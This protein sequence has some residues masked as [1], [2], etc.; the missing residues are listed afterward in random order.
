M[1]PDFLFE[2]SWEVCNKVGGIHTVIST[3]AK[4]LVNK[5]QDNYI[6]IGPDISKGTN[7][8]YEFIEDTHLYKAWKIYAKSKG[9][10]IRIGRWN[11]VGNPI[12]ILIDFSPFFN[13]KDAVLYELWDSFKVNSESGGWDYIEPLLF[14]Y[15]AGKVIENYYE[16]YHSAN[17][18][19]VAHFHEW[20]TGSG[21]LYLKK[22]CPQIA[23]T[24]TTHAT[25]LGRCI[26]GNNLP[27]YD[28]MGKY[29][30][31]TMSGNFHIK[32]KHLLESITAQE[33]DG[34]SVVSETTNQE[35]IHFLKK[36]AD[37]ITPNG[38]E[39]DFV[40]QGDAY[41]EKRKIAREKI[42]SVAEGLL[43]QPLDKNA[44]LVINSG[45][46]EFKNKGIDVFIDALGRLNQ[47]NLNRNIVAVIAIPAGHT[48]VNMEL[49]DR[50]NKQDFSFPVEGDFITHYLTDYHSDPI[51]QRIKKNNLKNSPKDKV[52]IIFIPSYLDGRDGII[53]LNYFDFLPAFDASAFPS[54]YEPW[55]YT[56]MESLAFSIP[57]VTTTLAG[58]G[59]WIKKDIETGVSPLAVLDRNDHNTEQVTIDL[60]AAL[61]KGLNLSNEEYE[62]LQ[63]K[64]YDISR[65]TLWANFIKYYD[66]LYEKALSKAVERF[67]SYSHKLPIAVEHPV[68]LDW[69]Q[70]PE[71]K[72]IYIRPV[73]PDSL[74]DLVRIC[75]NLWWSWNP[76]A[77]DLLISIS[78]EKFEQAHENPI[79]FLSSLSSKD[80]VRLEND[81][82]FMQQLNTVVA[83]FDA[84]MDEA[85][86]KPED[87]I[88][89][90]SM[91]FGLHDSLKIYSGGLGMLAGDYLKEA[92]DS[93]K[94]MIG[95]GLLYRNGYFTQQIS[96]SG[97]QI[98]VYIPQKF[99]HLP[100]HAVKNKSGEWMT[101]SI[102]LPGRTV[103]AK[104]WQYDV[105]RIPLYL[106]DTDIE[107]NNE[108]D[109]EIT[110]QLYGG[111]WENRLKQEM[112]LGMGGVRLIDQLGLT[113][114]VYHNN[115]GHSAFSCIE[116]M[117]NIM[118]NEHLSFYEAK[119]VVRSSTLFTT[120]TPVPAGHDAFE[121]GLLRM[122]ISHYADSLGLSWEDFMGLGRV[123]KKN[124]EEKF[125]M[126]ILAT[127]FSQEVNGV[128]KIHG[129]VS[130]EMFANLYPGYFPKELY[131]G[132]VTNGVHFPTWAAKSWRK[133]YE[134]TFGL[135]FMKDQSNPAYWEKI[136]EV[137][138]EV[139]FHE[140]LKQK[141][142]LIREVGERLKHEFKARGESPNLWFETMDH[143]Q[144]R[145]LTIGFARRFAT[146]K[147][148]HLLFTNLEKLKQLVN[149]P[150]RPLQFIFAGKAHPNDKA[151]Q[152]LI[153][154]IIKISKMPE[155][156]GRII[157]LENYDMQLAKFL[158]RGVDIWLNTPTR[159][160]E[161]SGTSGEKAIMNGVLN[162]SVL[163]GWWAEGWKPG[164]G[165]ALSEE[166]LYEDNELQNAMDAETIYDMLEEEI[167][168]MY[169]DLNEKGYSTRWAMQIKNTIAQISPHF[170]MKR[171]LDD[172]YK[173]FY[174]KLLTRNKLL[175]LN[176]YEDA[177]E[178]VEWKKFIVNSWGNIEVL[179][180]SYPNTTNNAIKLGTYFH[181][182]IVLQLN[183]IPAENIGV[184]MV[185]TEREN[186]NHIFKNAHPLELIEE[187]NGRAI[188]SLHFEA[189]WSG[190]Y[191]YAFRVYPTHHLLPHRQDF[192]LV[193]WI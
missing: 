187:K 160:L 157:F 136:Y 16:Y 185:I 141:E 140:H 162:F 32:A 44:F 42:L 161:A 5:L 134:E 151:G 165:W 68:S 33:V 130:R 64:S 105:G 146:Y 163:D 167:L 90:F 154:R 41:V 110:G 52:K 92:S 72:K 94:N 99:S 12:V 164:A 129:R 102:A 180:V 14:G 114:A 28:E 18:K 67:P 184:E 9:L 65:T 176:N 144:A 81:E 166:Q 100:L 76:E 127:N 17:D 4:M 113:P 55:G 45:R 186:E 108:E 47:S 152:D 168:P 36:P 153:K 21:A 149:N 183:N 115:E 138:D 179:R 137:D 61:Y 156:I 104:V 188:Y 8:N 181:A 111:N 192:P 139:I 54:Y 128:S 40:P 39:D 177:R 93:N 10:N 66:E 38:F 159:P 175:T 96:K 56:P 75:R 20:M 53:N 29:D 97:D 26:A 23:T 13:Q 24:F 145:A 79:L 98:S 143:I 193:K 120:H 106:L 84:Y 121:E 123:D 62:Q 6:L 63:K 112:L 150:D 35:C 109:R 70:K 119:E 182:E 178:L 126:S 83:H 71:W 142:Q 25:V 59:Q 49:I 80:L 78:S 77:R 95:I 148:A 101:V 169:Y 1:K 122:Y 11:I 69:G 30:P 174:N 89:Y 73:F 60:G 58:F 107:E 57:T 43:N 191:E 124:H 87:M 88:A 172:Y 133:L 31:E 48:S 2:T 189:T 118:K 103:Y 82:K 171:Q 131:I 27:L 37:V 22:H 155:F 158:T 170:T 91:E 7:I 125:S 19:I 135:E 85:R 46:Y 116:R 117:T 3:K 74:K 173:K 86:N 147:R 190:V 51:I 132:H 15:A 34:F 50:I